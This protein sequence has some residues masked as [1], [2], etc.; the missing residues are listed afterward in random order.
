MGIDNLRLNAHPINPWNSDTFSLI[1]V[2]PFLLYD[3]LMI[4][5]GGDANKPDWKLI[6]AFL[7]KEG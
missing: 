5:I 1:Q 6:K 7:L 3:L 2:C 4:D